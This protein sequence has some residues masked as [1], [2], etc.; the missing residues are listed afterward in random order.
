[1]QVCSF[2]N[3]LAAGYILIIIM[4]FWNFQGTSI[5]FCRLYKPC[6]H[7]SY[8]YVSCSL[9]QD[10]KEEAT[11]RQSVGGVSKALLHQVQ[12]H[13]KGPELSLG[14]LAVCGS[15]QF[16]ADRHHVCG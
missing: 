15:Q 13:L 12:I 14:G 4:K 6:I 7:V 2:L 16:L 11:N 10:Q 5:F 1:M 9:G 3:L 8:R